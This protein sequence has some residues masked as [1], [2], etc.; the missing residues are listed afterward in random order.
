MGK[1]LIN[2]VPWKW[3]DKEISHIFLS[4]KI[5]QSDDLNSDKITNKMVLNF[6]VFSTTIKGGIVC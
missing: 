2:G 3:L 1:E 5:I 6:N 4:A